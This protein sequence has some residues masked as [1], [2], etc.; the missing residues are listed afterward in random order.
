[1]TYYLNARLTTDEH[2]FNDS[3][4]F[5]TA[6]NPKPFTHTEARSHKEQQTTNTPFGFE[7]GM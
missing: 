3:K 7:P 4:E 1:L 2:E 5:V 6:Q